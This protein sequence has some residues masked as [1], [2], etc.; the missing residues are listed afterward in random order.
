MPPQTAKNLF[1]NNTIDPDYENIRIILKSTKLTAPLTECLKDIIQ[2]E[3]NLERQANV[4]SPIKSEENL[5]PRSTPRKASY[6]Q[7]NLKQNDIKLAMLDY[8]DT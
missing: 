4:G 2:R 3:D 7:K 6:S 5:I 1:L 8:L